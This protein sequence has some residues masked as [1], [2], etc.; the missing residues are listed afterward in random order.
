MRVLKE[1]PQGHLNTAL[2]F[3]PQS[4]EKQHCRL[5]QHVEDLVED[6]ED[7]IDP[8]LARCPS[9]PAFVEVKARAM[10]RRGTDRAILRM[11]DRLIWEARQGQDRSMRARIETSVLEE[12]SAHIEQQGDLEETLRLILTGITAGESLGFNRAFLFLVDESGE[13][14]KGQMAVGPTDEEEA[15]QVWSR[16]AEQHLTL[17]EMMYSRVDDGDKG[18][19]L[20][21]E[22]TRRVE[23][24]L[25]DAHSVLAQAVRRQTTLRMTD[26]P[27]E[28]VFPALVDATDFVVVPLLGRGQSVGAILADNRYSHHPIADRDVHMLE[29]LACLASVAIQNHRLSDDLRRKVD[30]LEQAY[31]DLRNH[32]ARLIE[33]ER[34]AAVGLWTSMIAHEIKNPLVS[35][36]GLARSV[37]KGISSDHPHHEI[38]GTIVDEVLRL[39]ALVQDIL[40]F[41]RA[42]ELQRRP[43][44]LDEIVEHSV[45]VMSRQLEESRIEVKM[46]LDRDLPPLSLDRDRMHQVLV[47]LMQNGI[48]AMQEGGT[49]RVSTRRTEE[50]IELEVADTGRGIPPE[51]MERLFEPFFTTKPHGSG[52]GLSICQRIV[53]RHNGR[54][55]ITQGDPGTC[56]IVRWPQDSR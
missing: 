33:S 29:A 42:G 51:A 25:N 30:E 14:L 12:I 4:K 20:L 47:N 3:C 56:V 36:G 8:L 6:A 19:H 46:E 13:K 22:Q 50:A 15:R 53:E 49:L 27:A 41:A 21:T 2:F 24:P 45:A 55:Q 17:K 38:L 35:I 5:L 7:L 34:M 11:L 52:L 1:N 39:E 40:H 48:H 43:V 44:Q 23:I 32:Q 26:R 18:D 16:I 10:G 54:I 9:C 28:A 31:K 37:K